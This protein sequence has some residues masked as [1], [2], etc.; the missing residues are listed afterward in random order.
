MV[1][2]LLEQRPASFDQYL[3][4]V[5]QALFEID[6]LHRSAEYDEGSLGE[7]LFF[8]ADLE[9][10]MHALSRDAGWQLPA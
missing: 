5:D 2:R 3:D 4:L 7:S 9:R 6:E 10:T 8:V 1:E